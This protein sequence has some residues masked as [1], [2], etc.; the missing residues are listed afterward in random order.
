M[1]FGFAKSSIIGATIEKCLSVTVV[2][3][4]TTKKKPYLGFKP[5]Q[6]SF[7]ILYHISPA[8]ARPKSCKCSAP[9]FRKLFVDPRSPHHSVMALANSRYTIHIHNTDCLYIIFFIFGYCEPF[10][11][12]SLHCLLQFV[13]LHILLPIDP[14]INTF[15]LSAHLCLSHI[16]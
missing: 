11:P 7:V 3:Q 10:G 5:R 6:L 12:C 9:S 8:G 16:I 1:G 14:Q 13:L 4:L 2:L 15:N